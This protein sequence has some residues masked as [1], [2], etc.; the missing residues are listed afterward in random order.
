MDKYKNL[1]IDDYT[2]Y[3]SDGDISCRSYSE[4]SS[5]LV[6]TEEYQSKLKKLVT[7]LEN[8]KEKYK[9]VVPKDLIVDLDTVKLIDYIKEK[10][11]TLFETIPEG[12][13]RLFQLGNSTFTIQFPDDVK[14]IQDDRS[15][16]IFK[17]LKTQDQT[18]ISDEVC[19]E[20]YVDD[21]GNL[22][23][24]D[25]T[26]STFEIHNKYGEEVLSGEFNKDKSFKSF[27]YQGDSFE[28]IYDQDHRFESIDASDEDYSS[29]M[30]LV[31]DPNEDTPYSYMRCIYPV[32]FIKFSNTFIFTKKDNNIFRIEE[33]NYYNRKPMTSSINYQFVDDKEA[34]NFGLLINKALS[35]DDT[36]DDS[37]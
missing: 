7:I 2:Q 21:D 29:Y 8:G 3:D 31:E 12:T 22:L 19:A 5:E 33:Y 20:Y 28:Y 1:I 36:N 13:E 24:I 16:I 34:E 11:L 17:Y 25:Y 18:L 4:N 35:K 6:I 9:Q 15:I 27:E 37:E 30:K 23:S 32:P 14:F 26:E 10:G